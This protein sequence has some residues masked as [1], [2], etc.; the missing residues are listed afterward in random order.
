MTI[1]VVGAILWY[2]WPSERQRALARLQE[3]GGYLGRPVIGGQRLEEL[4]VR[5]PATAFR[6]WPREDAV[7]WVEGK[8][9]TD[10]D[11]ALFV[12]AFPGVVQVHLG[13]TGVTDR[14]LDHLMKLPELRVLELQNTR[15]IVTGAV[16][17]VSEW[18][19]RHGCWAQAPP[20]AP[21]PG[22]DRREEHKG[23]AGGGGRPSGAIP[24]M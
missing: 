14:A 19:A 21:L 23:H 18:H 4:G 9:A 5:L 6:Y 1:A 13:G 22:R 16:E 2:Q 17:L 3:L 7:F 24:R 10:D 15:I 11:V 20:C 12:A 8:P